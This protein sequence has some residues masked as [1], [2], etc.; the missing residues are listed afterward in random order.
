MNLINNQHPCIEASQYSQ[1][2]LL[3]GHGHA[4]VQIGHIDGP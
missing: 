2:R 1:D 4:I 3:Y